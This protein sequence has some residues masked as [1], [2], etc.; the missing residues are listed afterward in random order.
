MA[1]DDCKVLTVPAISQGGRLLRTRVRIALYDTNKLIYPHGV[2]ISYGDV[3]T[4]KDLINDWIRPQLLGYPAYELINREIDKYQHDV[5]IKKSKCNYVEIS[6]EILLNNRNIVNINDTV[7]MKSNDII[8]LI[9]GIEKHMICHFYI[10][11]VAN[12]EYAV[13][14]SNPYTDTMRNIIKT[15][16]NEMS[17]LEEFHSFTNSFPEEAF[18]TKL[19]YLSKVFIEICAINVKKNIKMM[20]WAKTSLDNYDIGTALNRQ[21]CDEIWNMDLVNGYIKTISQSFETQSSYEF[22][23]HLIRV[24]AMYYYELIPAHNK[25]Y[26][27][28]LP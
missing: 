8:Y 17:Q 14:V 15:A 11:G 27:I 28:V 24:C 19:S 26:V 2:F 20:A 10:K 22:P 25:L 7:S 12:V 1:S 23:F 18:D 4:Y 5:M 16:I 13:S 3:A 21:Y 9:Y 6:K